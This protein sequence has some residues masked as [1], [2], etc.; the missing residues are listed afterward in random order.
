MICHS[1]ITFL[2]ICLPVQPVRIHRL[3]MTPNTYI[4]P[5]CTIPAAWYIAQNTIELEGLKRWSTGS[6][7][8]K[9]GRQARRRDD[10]VWIIARIKIGDHK[11]WGWKARGLMHKKM[12]TFKIA[13]V[14]NQEPWRNMR[15]ICSLRRCMHCLQELGGLKRR[16]WDIALWA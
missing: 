1:L 7:F 9:W 13:V 3:P 8:R 2:W 11:S 14:G 5:E 16:W 6:A 15:W 4:L 12:S 10:N